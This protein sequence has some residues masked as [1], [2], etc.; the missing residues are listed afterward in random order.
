MHLDPMFGDAPR[1]QGAFC[2]GRAGHG[3]D[4]ALNVI[5]LHEV[6]QIVGL[7]DLE[8]GDGQRLQARFVIDKGHGQYGI[9][10]CK[11][12]SKLLAGLTGP[13][14]Q[15][16]QAA[17]AVAVDAQ[18]GGAQHQSRG[19]GEDEKHHAADDIDRGRG[20]D[21]GVQGR[22]GDPAGG[23]GERDPARAEHALHFVGFQLDLVQAE[24]GGERRRDAHH[25]E[26][27]VGGRAK[28]ARK[29]RGS[30]EENHGKDVGHNDDQHIQR[31]EKR[32]FLALFQ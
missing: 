5:A 26:E 2:G 27:I 28:V 32:L 1:E 19:R 12:C 16:P 21:A 4:H 17:I 11:R 23:D 29:S 25:R 20:R 14:D 24:I 31:Q 15:H 18:E 22:E 30:H 6:R 8:T 7:V 3:K 13:V 10:G 9:V